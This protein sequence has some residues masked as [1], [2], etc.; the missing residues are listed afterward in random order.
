M[1]KRIFTIFLAIIMITS[2]VGCNSS[3]SPESSDE[4]EVIIEEEIIIEGGSTVSNESIVSSEISQGNDS[5]DTTVSSETPA[6]S[7]STSSTVDTLSEDNTVNIDYDWKSHPE[8]Y[9]L[10]AFTFDDG[11]DDLMPQYVQYFAAFDGAG[12]FFVNGTSIKSDYDYKKMQNAIDYGWDIGNHGD[13]H[14]VA[15][16]GG[17]GGTE[18]TYD[19]V[20]A[21]IC[22]L[23]HKLETN[24]KT[25]DGAAYQVNFYRPPN[26]KPTANS[27][28]I[29][30]EENLAVIWL[31]HDALDWGT[32]SREDSYNVFKKGIGTWEDGDIILCHET[33]Q[34]TYDILQE[35]LP[36]YFRAGYRFCSI[37]ELMEMRGITIDQI[38]GELNEVDG[39]RGMVTNIL[40]AAKAGKK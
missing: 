37:S 29:C 17:T 40:D 12:T 21:D 15:T 38:S 35:L 28:K 8:D 14:L 13:T 7:S 6:T 19:A 26:I 20:R 16:I 10:L 9:K 22:D 11:P 25:R 2:F 31:A 30:S 5:V 32:N 34:N 4:V 27:F 33:S 18:A 23:I 1:N 3:Q 36:D 39:N 24:L